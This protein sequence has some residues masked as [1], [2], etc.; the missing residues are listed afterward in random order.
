MVVVAAAAWRQLTA[1]GVTDFWSLNSLSRRP[2]PAD[3]SL[4]RDAPVP[5]PLIYEQGEDRREPPSDTHLGVVTVV[6]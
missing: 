5:A 6:L 3:G 2:G 1:G 4:R